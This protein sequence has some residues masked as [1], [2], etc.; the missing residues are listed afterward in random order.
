MDGGLLVYDVTNLKS[1]ESVEH[2]L[3]RLHEHSTHAPIVLLGNK[4]DL[5]DRQVSIELAR[6]FAANENL[7]LFE[8]SCKDNTEVNNAFITLIKGK[9]LFP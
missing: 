1:F 5:P 3:E 8:T 4:N 6:S 7:A 9:Q 2:R